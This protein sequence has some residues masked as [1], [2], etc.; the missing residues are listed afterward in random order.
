MSTELLV[1]A[2]EKVPLTRLQTGQLSFHRYTFLAGIRF[3]MEMSD[4]KD[5]TNISL[6][7][8]ARAFHG[9]A[10]KTS[11]KSSKQ[12]IRRLISMLIDEG[13]LVVPDYEGRE[14][15]GLTYVRNIP[16]NDDDDVAGMIASRIETAERQRDVKQE[17]LEQLK[18]NYQRVTSPPVE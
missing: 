8:F 6:D 1:K 9:T 16:D 11:R 18:S 13:W 15:A 10:S 17:R 5:V 4:D 12:Q 2:E 3:V 7:D 14:L